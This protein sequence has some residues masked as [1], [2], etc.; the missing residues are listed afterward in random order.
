MSISP[1][2][3][4]QNLIFCCCNNTANNNIYNNSGFPLEGG[5]SSSNGVGG[6]INLVSGGGRNSGVIK[7]E[8]IDTDGRPSGDIWVKSGNVKEDMSGDVLLETGFATM[9]SGQSGTITLRAGPAG[10]F[11]A[12]TSYSNNLSTYDKSWRKDSKNA[13][14]IELE[15]GSSHSGT[16]GEID[17]IGGGGV[18]Q[19]GD[20]N[21]TSGKGFADSKGGN[22]YISGGYSRI[23][24]GHTILSGGF[25]RHGTGGNVEILGGDTN[26]GDGGDIKIE[27]GVTSG[28][29]V[30][31]TADGAKSEV[32]TTLTSGQSSDISGQV[33]V[34]SGDATIAGARSGDVVLQSAQ[35]A[36]KSGTISISSG[37]A[38]TLSGDVEV[39]T[40]KSIIEWL[41]ISSG[42]MTLST[43]DVTGSK[44]NSGHVK[45][46]SGNSN[47]GLSGN[48]TISTVSSITCLL[49]VLSH[50]YALAAI[51]PI[52]N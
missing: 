3:N 38:G 2:S 26:S 39:K 43:A 7:I 34:S 9:K 18:F 20:V 25:G 47:S 37:F 32:G 16:G 30:I 13:G 19:G 46:A 35:A 31:K 27:S 29:I 24:G 17:L 21:I 48:V 6:G 41:D 22:T 10:D 45:I 12:H 11:F 8:S 28:S 1:P 15:S 40:G 42:S 36:T 51:L 50:V 52:S 23:N 33:T 44:G 5:T 14:A 4:H 49:Y